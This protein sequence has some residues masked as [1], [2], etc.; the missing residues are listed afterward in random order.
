MNYRSFCLFLVLLL[1]TTGTA[2][3]QESTESPEPS[4]QLEIMPFE[5]LDRTYA[6]YIPSTYDE[7]EPSGLL[8]LL[9]GSGGQGYPMIA[10]TNLAAQAEQTGYILVAPDGIDGYWRYL[11]IYAEEDGVDDMAFL[12][13]LIDHLS[14][15]YN[16][17][18][19]RLY[20][21][22]F[23]NGGV[24]ALRMRCDLADK[25]AGV[26]SLGATPTFGLSQVCLDA[27]PFPTMIVLGTAD[28]AMP[29]QGDAEVVDGVMYS[30]FS[31][32]QTVGYLNSLNGCDPTPSYMGA[33][34]TEDSAIE[35]YLTD[36]EDCSGNPGNVYVALVDYN[37]NW[38]FGVRVATA[39]GNVGDFADIL[40]TFFAANPRA[41][42][43]NQ[44]D[45]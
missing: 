23:S 38:P 29:W 9:H 17:D 11:D 34:S 36:F 30:S 32:S 39:G 40:W 21:F 27:D 16:V 19:N 37:H 24:M 4:P 6:L 25:L 28:E 7:N 45:E 41:D 15:Q 13:A 8:L 22:G 33:I 20:V 31:M 12:V 5:G 1:L 3:A 42:D 26:V 44:E 14:E 2:I 10:S 35:V 43:G 18:Q